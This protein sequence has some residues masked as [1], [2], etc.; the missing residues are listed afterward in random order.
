M[1]G[2][3]I[4]IIKYHQNEVVNIGYKKFVLDQIMIDDDSKN[5]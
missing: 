1:A 4:A 2:N 3:Y 5:N